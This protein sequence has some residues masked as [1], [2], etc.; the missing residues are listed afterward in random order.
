[1]LVEYGSVYGG[2][3]NSAGNGKGKRGAYS[4]ILG[5]KNVVLRQKFETYPM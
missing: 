5:G 1:M 4:S 3:R 2:A